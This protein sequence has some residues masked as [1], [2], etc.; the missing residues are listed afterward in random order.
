[1]LNRMAG[2]KF[3]SVDDMLNQPRQFSKITGTAS[4]HP[5]GSVSNTPMPDD[6]FMAN[7]NKA[8]RDRADGLRSDVT[9]G[10]QGRGYGVGDMTQYYGVA[11]G[12]APSPTLQRRPHRRRR[13]RLS[14]RRPAPS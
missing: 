13:F 12:Q 3:A 14:W 10:G 8:M 6:E 5:Y 4:L 11:P 7:W 9:G 2:G 1:M